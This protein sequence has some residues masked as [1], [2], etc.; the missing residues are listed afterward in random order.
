MIAV[1]GTGALLGMREAM[2]KHDIPGTV[3][4]VGTPA[5]EGGAGKIKL[6][7]M[8]GCGSPLSP[9]PSSLL[10]PSSSF[11]PVLSSFLPPPSSLLPPLPLDPMI[12]MLHLLFRF[13]SLSAADASPPTSQ[14]L[15]STPA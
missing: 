2:K 1:A 6:L 10:P 13:G 7:E 5:E 11:R 12:I 8:G 15:A 3:V 14:T 9:P 4:L